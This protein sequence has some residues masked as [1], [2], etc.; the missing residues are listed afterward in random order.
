M[1]RTKRWNLERTENGLWEVR[2]S[3]W[4][5]FHDYIR[6]QMLNYS[7]YVW[8]GQA[9]AGWKLKSSLDR[10]LQFTPQRQRGSKA[11]AHLEKFKYAS[12]GR[13][14]VYAP[15]D[16]SENDWWA[17]GQHNG[18]ATPLLDWSESPFVSLYFAFEQPVSSDIKYRAV[19]ALSNM[20]RA[21]TE[22]EK[23]HRKEYE[24]S[25][26]TLLTSGL[27]KPK[28]PTLDFVRP[29]QDDNARLVNQNGLFTRAP[30]GQ[31][32]EDWVASTHAE[33]KDGYLIKLLIP[34]KDRGNCLRT[35]N[36]MNINNNT[37]FPDLYGAGKHCNMSLEISGL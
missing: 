33:S 8:R 30:I 11:S 27:G 19:W 18:L 20:D 6:Q 5:Y 14:N 2:L 36:N 12:R 22:I 15:K 35:L 24:N 32:V 16:L 25:K 34:N 1:A 28:A 9:D 29:L 31:T 10:R 21:N 13:R 37:L 23:S 26:N 4:K 3:S 17:L 7:H